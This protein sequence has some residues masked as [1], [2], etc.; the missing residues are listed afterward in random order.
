MQLEF[1]RRPARRPHL[2]GLLLGLVAAAM[3]AETAMLALSWT[4]RA[5]ELEALRVADGR[6]APAARKTPAAKSDPAQLARLRSAQSAARAL[7][8]PWV[9]LLRAIESAPQDSVALLAFEPSATKQT[10][11]LKAEARDATAMLAYLEALQRDARL[12]SVVLTSHQL[13]QQ[14]PG[15]PLRFQLQASWGVPN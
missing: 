4:H 9:D 8:T 15:T 3:I 6:A 14:A 1:A 10:V 12:A 7:T 11:R 2:S 13:Q 5:E